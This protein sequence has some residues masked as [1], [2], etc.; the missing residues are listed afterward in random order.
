VIDQSSIKAPGWQR[1]VAELQAPA[2][3][4]ATFLARMVAILG[5]VSGAR[6]SVLFAV[7][8]ESEDGAAGEPR[9]IVAWPQTS[10]QPGPLEFAAEARNAARMAAE[11]GQVGV[12]S[13][14]G[15]GG[16]YGE[17]ERGFIIGVPVQ[18]APPE[19]TIA[20]RGVV[21]LLVEKRSRQA[22]QTSVA[23]V[24]VLAGYTALHATRQQVRRLRASTAA[25]DL[26]S[27]LIAAI[28]NADN[29]R[30]AAIQLVNDVSRQIRADR[31]A[32]GWVHGIG[33]S[34]AVR[35]VAVSDTEHIDRR[36]AMMQKIE[37]AMDECLDQEQ[38]VLYPPPP[39]QGPE[40]QE[41]DVLLSQ[42]ITH[43]HRELASADARLKIISLPLRVEDEVVGVL[44][45]ES[46]A[47]GPADIA[48][49][50]LIQASMDLIAPIMMLRRSDDRHLAARA[51]VSTIRAGEWLVGPKH[52]AWKLVGLAVM[53]VAILVT[54]VHV[55]YRVEAPL[56]LEARER[57]IVSIPF[58]GQIASVPAGI[59]PGREVKRGDVLL[60][61]NTDEWRLQRLDA[62]NER[63]SAERHAEQAQKE[64]KFSEMQQARARAEQSRA[65]QELAEY[66]IAQATLVSPID[67]T[68]IAGDVRDR[69]GATVRLGDAVMQV[70][71]LE[72]MTIVARVSD[73]DIGLLRDASGG[74]PTKGALITK[75]F[76][77]REFPFTVERIVPLSLPK[78]GKNAFEVRG[79]MD[80][81]APW[82]RPGAE[83]LAKFDTGR[84]SLLWIGTRR[85][86]D[87][88]R[89]WLWW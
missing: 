60:V 16:F 35:V 23:M 29:F 25:L 8:R 12:F 42:A 86:R 74:E 69:V 43:A 61:M 62:M 54:F 30:G 88:L 52:T 83:G 22:M 38:P 41:A 66:K 45:I 39:P 73:N 17:Q 3:D 53:I 34:G 47:Q 1:I 80:T 68:I 40:G 82:L 72:K 37:A 77:K 27:G 70:A 58:D 10:D 20:P 87:Q 24:E 33:A 84:H 44:T 6:Q 19:N 65:K 50:E 31:V 55:P 57:Q 79:V 81:P 4:D 49:V 2:P 59:E 11:S 48:S 14:D 64:G 85:I 76:P 5:Q 9:V 28:N 7:D 56:E 51:Y 13:L 89:L 46:T 63:I 75:A 78:D 21:T 67:G 26:A 15:G 32:M 36:M 18:T 71:P